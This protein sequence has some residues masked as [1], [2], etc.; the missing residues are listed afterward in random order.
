MKSQR[1]IFVSHSSRDL[2]LA[3]ALVSFLKGTLTIG[4]D[5]EILCTSVPGHRLKTGNRDGPTIRQAILEC[6]V[7]I[8]LL[9]PHTEE[10]HFVWLELGAAWAFDKPFVPA[11]Y[12]IDPSSM[13]PWIQRHA[14]VLDNFEDLSRDLVELGNDI[15]DYSEYEVKGTGESATAAAKFAKVITSKW[16]IDQ[17]EALKNSPFLRAMHGLDDEDDE[18]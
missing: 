3:K 4:R 18:S 16:S 6:E 15:A 10:S 13:P 17:E 9:T 14:A 12:R 1:R 5:K 11:T 2:D 8:A 7:F